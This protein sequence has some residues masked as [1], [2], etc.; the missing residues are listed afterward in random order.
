MA[1]KAQQK[2]KKAKSAVDNDAFL[3]VVFEFKKSKIIMNQQQQV[4]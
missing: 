2:E 3:K 4:L 1:Y